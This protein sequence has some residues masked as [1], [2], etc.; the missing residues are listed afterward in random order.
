MNAELR[1]GREI[2]IT[3]GEKRSR[4][5][6]RDA[7]RRYSSKPEGSSSTKKQEPKSPLQKVGQIPIRSSESKKN[8][9]SPGDENQEEYI[10]T[11]E[12]DEDV[13]FNIKTSPLRESA[14]ERSSSMKHRRNT[15]GAPEKGYYKNHPRRSAF[16]K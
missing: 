9:T 13:E 7:N 5:P 14:R 10:K 3:K 2:V 16:K 1:D 15:V 12:Y 4:T 8:K 11:K 6:V